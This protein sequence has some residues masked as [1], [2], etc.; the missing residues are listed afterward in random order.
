VGDRGGEVATWQAIINYRWRQ[1]PATNPVAVKRF[2]AGHGFLVVDGVFGPVTEQA[3]RVYQREFD[4]KPTGIVR[5]SSW[6]TSRSA[7]SLAAELG[8]H[9]SR[10]A[11]G[12]PR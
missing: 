10:R 2:I 12:R 8:I 4:L 1:A 11:S 3:T 7:T 9:S 6:K 5:F